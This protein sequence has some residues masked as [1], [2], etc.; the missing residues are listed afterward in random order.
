M[1]YLKLYTSNTLAG[2]G[3]QFVFEND[4]GEEFRTGRLFYKIQ[5]GGKYVYSLLFSNIIDS[6]FSDGSICKRNRVCDE[7]FIESAKIAVCPTC[8]NDEMVEV[9]NFKPLSFSGAFS[10]KVNAGEFFCSDGV[11]LYA[12]A[13]EYVCVEITF[14]GKTL[15]YHEETIIPTFIKKGDEWVVSKQMPFPSMIGCQRH[16]KR[17]IAF[18]G[19][20]ITQGIGTAKNS[21]AHWNALLADKLGGDYSY[22]NLG[23]G[24][25]R[26]DDAASGGAW[27]FKAKQNDVVFVCFGVN[28]I[29][30]G[31]SAEQIKQNLKTIVEELKK[32][33]IVVVL[34]TVPP[35]NYGEA[36]LGIWEDVNNYIKTE[37]C[38]ICDMVFD[39]VPVL[40]DAEKGMHVSKYGAHPNEEGCKA[41]ADALWNAIKE[42]KTMDM[43]TL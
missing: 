25:G 3:N 40:C 38:E 17:R 15:P 1:D 26:A 27:M 8:F 43:L 29:F 19:D 16:V 4:N 22:W 21:Y 39:N 9:E 5:F 13:G 36:T 31:Y 35:F 6:T 11:E 23:L 20:S 32:S 18:W 14:K 42:E 10:K 28:D 7:W 37:L 34:Q 33:G 30:K 2:S 24:F 41:W 12:A